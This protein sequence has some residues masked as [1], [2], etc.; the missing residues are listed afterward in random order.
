MSIAV[1]AVVHPSRTLLALLA[2]MGLLV[3]VGGVAIMLAGVF[4]LPPAMRAAVGGAGPILAIGAFFAGLRS[5]K[6]FRLDISGVGQ[7]RLM[8]YS[9][10]ASG[11]SRKP[12]LQ[13]DAAVFR[14][15]ENSVLWPHLLMVRLE[16]SSGVRRLLTILPDCMSDEEFKAVSVACRWIAAH[17]ICHPTI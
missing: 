2:A 4:D 15:V 11:S 6:T 8:E 14:L 9:G 10:V 3:C 5:R 12:S 7:I 1:S 13:E 16:S 17:N